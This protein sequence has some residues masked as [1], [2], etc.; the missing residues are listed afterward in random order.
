VFEI[1][2]VLYRPADR[3]KGYGSEAVELLTSWLFEQGLAERVQGG[4]AA[5]NG[6]MR[7]V[8]ECLGFQLEGIMRAVMPLGDGTR[9]D[10]A[11][12]AALRSEW[13]SRP[14]PSD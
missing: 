11:M 2:L 8:L 9:A 10:G 14:C 4:T 1:G 12:Y 13:T 5:D 3:G 7:L 6:P